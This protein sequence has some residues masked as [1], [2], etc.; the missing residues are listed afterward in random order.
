[1]K[2]WVVQDVV[3]SQLV[4][5]WYNDAVGVDS[6]D[7]VLLGS[8]SLAYLPNK[9]LLKCGNWLN[10]GIGNSVISDLVTY[11]RFSPAK[12]SAPIYLLYVGEND[13]YRGIPLAQVKAAVY[14][15][16]VQLENTK[17]NEQSED[18]K[19]HLLAIKPSPARKV[20]WALF[21]DF[22]AYLSQLANAS[23]SRYF[24]PFQRPKDLPLDEVFSADGVH[25]TAI[26]YHIFFAGF[27]SQCT[28][29][30]LKTIM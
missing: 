17:F 27:N 25:L 18:V 28:N 11:L 19:I 16:I 4:N 3:R 2:L 9:A 14:E 21:E 10:R 8:S 26:G 6:F 13:L 23:Q 7:G 5:Y 22:N 1:M 24:H 30:T 12:P 29:T 20:K 15:L